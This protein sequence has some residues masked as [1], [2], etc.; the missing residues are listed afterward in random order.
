MGGGDIE[1][2]PEVVSLSDPEGVYDPYIHLLD[3]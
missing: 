2:A 3:G 1:N